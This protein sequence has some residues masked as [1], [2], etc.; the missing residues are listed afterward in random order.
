VHLLSRLPAKSLRGGVHVNALKALPSVP[1]EKE[2]EE[3][4]A[5]AGVRSACRLLRPVVSAPTRF[6]IT[7]VTNAE[8]ESAAKRQKVDINQAYSMDIN[9]A[10]DKE[11]ETSLLST[12]AEAPVSALQGIGPKTVEALG[13]LGVKTVKDLSEYKCVRCALHT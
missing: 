4:I 1:R 6:R 12:I 9:G 13:D 2:I 10:V 11:Y 7:M 8:D 3:M 5:Y